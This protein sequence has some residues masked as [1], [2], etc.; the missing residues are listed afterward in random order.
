MSA[1]PAV[2]FVG[3]HRLLTRGLLVAGDRG[4]VACHGA[5]VS[6]LLAAAAGFRAPAGT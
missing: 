4:W 1:D 3:R 2:D 5:V 6:G